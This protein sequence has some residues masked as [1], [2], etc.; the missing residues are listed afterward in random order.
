[1]FKK[2][3]IAAFFAAVIA[4]VTFPY[5][6][7]CGMKYDTCVLSCDLRQ[8]NDGIAKAACRAECYARKIACNSNQALHR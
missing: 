5:W 7:S 8:R 6:G 2:V 3:L 1:M 4:I